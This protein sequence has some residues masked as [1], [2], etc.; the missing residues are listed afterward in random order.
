MPTYWPIVL[1]GVVAAVLLA[2]SL[3]A[4]R[5]RSQTQKETLERL[6]FTP[7][8]DKHAWLAETV[9][10]IDNNKDYDY[11]VRD[12]KRLPREPAIYYYIK[13]RSDHT[14]EDPLVEEELL[15]PLS[16]RSPAGLVLILKPSSIAPGR[17]TRLLSAVATASWDAQPD[18]LERLELPMDLKD[19]N[20]LGALGPPGA[21][22]YDLADSRIL[23][24]AQ[25][26]GDVGAM[27]MYFRDSW[28]LITGAGPQAPFR[29]DEI[30]A[31]MR[32]LL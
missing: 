26:L 2:W 25:G 27:Q 14:R 29:I 30:I 9:A 4:Q 18:D 17:A 10:R 16:R 22:L 21:S 19:T 12:A 31:R 7:C 3:A 5:R 15:F 8:P 23:S 11:E 20:L 6:G 32:P 13:R 24:V 28:C 1:V